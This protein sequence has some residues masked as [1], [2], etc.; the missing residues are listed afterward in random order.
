L[1]DLSWADNSGIITIPT[2]GANFLR[3]VVFRL[4][5]LIPALLLPLAVWI[6]AWR[7]AL[8]NAITASGAA[9][10]IRFLLADSRFYLRFSSGIDL[11]GALQLKKT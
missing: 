11:F 2:I 10:I 3:G 4:A 8:R 7:I 9:I 6:L 5:V 1:C